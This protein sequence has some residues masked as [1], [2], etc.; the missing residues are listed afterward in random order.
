[1]VNLWSFLFKKKLRVVLAT[2]R[3]LVMFQIGQQLL[4]LEEEAFAWFVTVWKHVE[5]G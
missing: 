4:E 2:Q 5:F 1:M 3:Q